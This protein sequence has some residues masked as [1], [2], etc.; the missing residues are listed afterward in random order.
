[1]PGRNRGLAPRLRAGQE[2]RGVNG[3]FR[4][5]VAATYRSGMTTTLPTAVKPSATASATDLRRSAEVRLQQRWRQQQPKAGKRNSAGGVRRLLYELQIHQVELELQNA[6][7]QETRDRAEAELE[8][9]GELYDFA[10]V[11]YLTLDRGAVI[12]EAN[13]AGASL[14]GTARR[15]LMKQRFRAFVCPADRAAFDAFLEQVFASGVREEC[16][17]RLL[18]SGKQSV[19]VRL[20]ANLSASGRACRVAVTDVT[21]YKLAEEKVRLSEIRYR[22]SLKRRVAA[23]SS[24]IPRR[25]RLPMRTRS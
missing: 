20:R 8:K 15:A 7:L 16:D 11:G 2:I 14:L 12:C 22:V 18:V 21:K 9:F 4:V 5:Y 17:L 25:G 13:L 24:W 10:P 1:M 3:V 19:D 6:E 23:S